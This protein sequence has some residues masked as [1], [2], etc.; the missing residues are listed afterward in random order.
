MINPVCIFLNLK[1]KTKLLISYTLIAVVSISII[2]IS[3]YKIYENNSIRNAIAFS[4]KLSQQLSFNISYKINDFEDST[5]LWIRNYP[6]L[7]NNE[8]SLDYI[9]T[10]RLYSFCS[11]YVLSN[12]YVR[13]IYIEDTQQDSFIYNKF[14]IDVSNDA[15]L[16]KYAAQN[17]QTIIANWGRTTW[18]TLAETPG[19]IYMCRAIYS[20]VNLKYQGL[21]VV[22]IDRDYITELYD[23]MNQIDDSK[24]FLY[25]EDGNII[26]SNH[27][28]LGLGLAFKKY[29]YPTP[30]VA[31]NPVEYRKEKF[32]FTESTSFNGKW[33]VMN[34]L[35]YG[36]VLLDAQAMRNVILLTSL[37][38]FLFAI[39]VAVFV[40]RG[41]TSSLGLLLSS[42]RQIGKGDFN[43][44][45]QLNRSDEIGELASEF[46]K[47]AARLEE[48]LIRIA[49]EK[50]MKEKAEYRRLEAE[51]NA[52]QS[53]IN[54]HMINNILES[55][56]SLAKLHHENKISAVVTRLGLLLRGSI[57]RG[58]S[59]IPLRQELEY[60]QNYLF[61]QKELMQDRIQIEYDIEEQTLNIPIP[62]LILQ[63]LVENAIQ[64]GIDQKRE[65]GTVIISSYIDSDLHIQVS[66]NGIG[67]EQKLIARI[68]ADGPLEISGNHRGIGLQ[69][70]NQRIKM[71]YGNE[72]GLSIQSAAGE[73]TTV[74]LKL[75]AGK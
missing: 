20:N 71:L 36:D 1:I 11:N 15:N 44:R 62:K 31:R 73:G 55:I 53:Q 61:I 69:S 17:R 66:D 16:K 4:Q 45:S 59:I 49:D 38:C 42:I 54:P 12:N 27:A 8:Q 63:P 72:Y 39:T 48:M 22:S 43:V 56:N 51:F 65:G 30:Q 47:M 14:S 40:S 58:N 9:N 10:R 75:P 23:N 28:D 50:N 64:H 68:F 35:S 5:L 52:L 24:I 74:T 19:L 2:S 29:I 37:I 26:Y 18:F 6:D 34:V 32:F 7:F 67:M 3:I 70:V 33:S 25:F 60:V 46:N 21:I 57:L 41:I 13:Q